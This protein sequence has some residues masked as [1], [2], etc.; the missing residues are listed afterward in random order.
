MLVAGGNAIDAAVATAFALAVVH[1]TAGNI[2]GGGF[3][4]YRPARGEAG[5]LRLSRDRPGGGDSATMFLRDGVYDPVRHHDSHLAVGV[6]GHGG[7]ASPGVEGA[8]ATP[9]GAAPRAGDRPGPRRLH[10]D[11]R[12]GPVSEGRAAGDEALPSVGRAV[13]SRRRS[14]TRWATSSSSWISPRPSS[15]SPTRDP[16]GFYEGKTAE[17]IEKE[18]KRGGGL[19]T[20]DDLKAYRPIRRTP[21][22][23]T[24][25]GLEILTMPPPSSGGVVLLQVLNIL[26][27]YDLPGMGFGSAAYL[28]HL[29]EALRRAFADR[30]RHLGDPDFVEG[31]AGGPAHL[32]GA[33]RRAP[34]HDPAPPRLGL[35][36]PPASSGRR[37]AR[38]PPTSRSWTPTAT[39]SRSPTPSRRATARRSWS[40]GPA[41]C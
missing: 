10:G 6:P 24:Y 20:R 12:A 7:G 5:G 27:G 38:R 39:P 16:R 41:S 2:G 19:I 18:M 40:R 3:L 34:G 4:V 37:R 1:P 29:T 14:P 28:H 25:H 35:E 11:R 17:L 15:G 9:V 30:A 13:L 33:R 8:R 32:E 22:R 26:E 21:L 23:G 36:R 31:H